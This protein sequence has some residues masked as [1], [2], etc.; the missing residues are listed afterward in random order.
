MIL[1]GG[2]SACSQILGT[3]LPCANSDA[4]QGCRLVSRCQ[5]A[6]EDKGF[7]LRLHLQRLHSCW[8]FVLQGLKRQHI[9]RAWKRIQEVRWLGSIDLDTMTMTNWWANFLDSSGSDQ[10]STLKKSKQSVVHVL[11]KYIYIYLFVCLLIFLS[12][13]LSIYSNLI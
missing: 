9:P 12:I 7:P 10:S 11:Y 4:L 8:I 1:M 3:S 5:A 13:C 6:E 2:S